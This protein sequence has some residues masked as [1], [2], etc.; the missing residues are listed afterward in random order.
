M[1]YGHLEMFDLQMQNLKIVF[2]GH[3]LPSLLVSPPVAYGCLNKHGPRISYGSAFVFRGPP[4]L[5]FSC[6]FP[7]AGGPEPQER[8]AMLSAKA[9][10]G[11]AST[12]GDCG[13]AARGSKPAQLPAA[14]LR[15]EGGPMNRCD[16][17]VSRP[18]VVRKPKGEPQFL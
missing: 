12:Q 5:R 13:W 9:S 10:A 7:L 8:R 1:F 16:V 15:E 6:W 14:L 11:S 17:W 3:P 18:F 4:E 2:S